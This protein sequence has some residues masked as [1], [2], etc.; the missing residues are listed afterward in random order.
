MIIDF[1]LN[2]TNVMNDELSEINEIL[3]KKIMIQRLTKN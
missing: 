2:P 1:K 3:K